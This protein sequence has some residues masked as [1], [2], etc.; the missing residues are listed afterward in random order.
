[1][2]LFPSAH[3][4]SYS[5]TTSLADPVVH[6]IYVQAVDVDGNEGWKSF[7]L[8]SEALQPLSKIEG[9][10]QHGLPNTP[11]PVPFVVEVRDPNDGSPHGGLPVTFTVTTGDGILNVTRDTTDYSGRVETT[12]TLGPNLGINTV[13]VSVAGIEDTVTFNAVA[14]PEVAL[15]DPNL[16]AVVETI[17][18]K[19]EEEPIASAE[20][21]T[22]T[23]LQALGADIRNLTGL[24][25]ATNLTGVIFRNNNIPDIAP[26]AGLTNLRRLD[27]DHNAISDI[28]PLAG[29]TEMQDLL[30]QNNNIS[31]ISPVAGLYILLEL[32]LSSNNITDIS[33]VAGLVHLGWLDLQGNNISDISPVAGLTNLTGLNLADNG[34]SDIS[35]LVA[36][37]GLGRG[38]EV[39]VRGNPLSYQ[40]LVAH[41]PALQSRGVTVEFDDQVPP[42]A[43]DINSDGKVDVFDL[44]L[45]AA[46]LGNTG[47]NLPADVNSDESVNILDLVLVAGRFGETMAGPSAQ[48]QLPET[49]TAAEV[50]SWLSDARSLEVRDT[51]TKRG[52]IT[53]EQLLAAL[54]P[55]ETELLANYPNPFN[56]E[57]WIPYRLAEDALV[58]LTIYDLS[59][60][61]VRTLNVGH[62]I[63]AAYESQSKAIYWNGKN[64][65]GEQVASGVYY[66]SLTAGE[67]SATRKM[68]ILK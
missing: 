63:A 12:L 41:I 44:V 25:D 38:D 67:F 45:V 5:I 42:V 57:T 8:F 58:T 32:N 27:L 56:P 11:L 26:I 31:D 16:R 22:L 4:P 40:S 54:T 15:P 35:P 37:T 9:D 21:L 50:Q 51:I 1:M 2:A 53:L 30:L 39:D 66:Y 10:N 55:R 68:V 46:Q 48:P 23:C 47:I 52:I 6:P 60:Q 43:A 59:G 13:E 3:D 33:P 28:S 14:G 65:L 64:S 61:V 7:S 29:L 36:N 24:E 34:I 18:N 17:L 49:L 19:A 20:M 62:R